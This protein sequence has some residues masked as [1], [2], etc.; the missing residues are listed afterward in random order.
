[1]TNDVVMWL[2][3]RLHRASGE[4]RRR[5]MVKGILRETETLKTPHPEMDLTG[6]WAFETNYN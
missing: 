4:G 5:A 3:E 1:M 6:F 2:L